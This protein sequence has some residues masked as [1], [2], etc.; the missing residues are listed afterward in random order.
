MVGKTEKV[1]TTKEREIEYDM[2]NIPEVE[3]PK[4]D[5]TK[6]IGTKAKI[7]S[8][9][10]VGTQYGRAFKFETEVVAKEGTKEKPIDIK[11]TKLIGL[12]QD[13]NGTWGISKDS[14]AKEFFTKYKINNHKDMIGKVVI[15]Q[16]TEPKN[17]VQFL[18]FN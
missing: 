1:N 5:V 3:M 16:A 2:D 10:V 18:S 13:E 9:K 14:K 17:G 12:Q 6:Y 7:V 8:A 4:I 15:L 11:G